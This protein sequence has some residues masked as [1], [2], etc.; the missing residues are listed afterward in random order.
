[1]RSLGAASI[2][3]LLCGPIACPAPQIEAKSEPAPQPSAAT[4]P[5]AAAPP[6][7]TKRPELVGDP[8]AAEREILAIE[9]LEVSDDLLLSLPGSHGRPIGGKGETLPIAEGGRSIGAPEA[10]SLEGGVQLPFDPGSYTRRDASRSYAT[11][12]TLRTIRAAFGVLR[13]ERGVTAEVM[14]GDLSLPR[15]GAFAPHVSHTSGRDMD[16]RLVLAEGLDRTTLPLLPEQVDW[17]ATWALV[18]SFLETGHVTYVFLDFVQ[19]AHLRRAAQRAGV[20]DRVLDRWFQ[21]PDAANATAIVRHEPGHR[22]H[23]HIRLN[24]EGQGPRCHGA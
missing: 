23:L 2:G 21:F 20:H 4:R 14:I 13:D 22:A 16:I 1:M 19:Q 15:G 9:E 8:S 5:I 10:G 12:Q 6:L 11:T 24:C 3:L 18:H 17:D 7:A